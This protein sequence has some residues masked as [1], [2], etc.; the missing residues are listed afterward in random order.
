MGKLAEKTSLLIQSLKETSD[1]TAWREIDPWLRFICCLVTDEVKRL[2]FLRHKTLNRTEG[3]AKLNMKSQFY[4][5]IT[6][7]FNDEE[8]V[9]EV[10]KNLS[11]GVDEFARDRKIGLTHGT[12]NEKQAKERYQALRVAL[13]KAVNNWNVSGNGQFQFKE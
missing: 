7:V 12:I 11:L 6:E 5:A 10:K 2:F 13:S 9:F 8:K 3:E 1:K 4:L